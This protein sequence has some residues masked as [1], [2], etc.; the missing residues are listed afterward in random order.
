MHSFVVCSRQDVD[1]KKQ[2]RREKV[3]QWQEKMNKAGF[4]DQKSQP[5]NKVH[6]K[7]KP[8][9]GNK[10]SATSQSLKSSE[11]QRADREAHRRNVVRFDN[12]DYFEIPMDVE[13]DSTGNAIK[14]SSRKDA[15]CTHFLFEIDYLS[16][17]KCFPCLHR[18]I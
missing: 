15:I 11:S 14:F 1:F 18:L 7:K 5:G 2:E 12:D 17:R 16:N 8:A 4:S 6:P 3:R 9:K 13:S 10:R